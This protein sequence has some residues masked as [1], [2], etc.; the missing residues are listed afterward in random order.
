M[1]RSLHNVSFHHYFLFSL[2]ILAQ[3]HGKRI[4]R[5]SLIRISLCGLGYRRASFPSPFLEILWGVKTSDKHSILDDK[6]NVRVWLYRI[7][8][9][10]HHNIVRE[11]YFMMLLQLH[12]SQSVWGRAKKSLQPPFFSSH[13][14]IYTKVTVSTSS[15]NL[16]LL[17][18]YTM[19]HGQCWMLG[20]TMALT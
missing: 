3:H 13:G 7:N 4:F 8:V 1:S 18:F 17:F 11:F 15:M 12:M 20:C 5:Y 6:S 19:Q 14:C 16:Y 9:G 10:T 2:S